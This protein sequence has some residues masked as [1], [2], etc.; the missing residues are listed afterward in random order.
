[1]EIWAMGCQWLFVHIFLYLMAGMEMFQLQCHTFD[2]VSKS[3]TL[4]TLQM[5]HFH[6]EFYILPSNKSLAAQVVANFDKI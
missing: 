1:M 6:Q 5:F 3:E 2:V 4:Q